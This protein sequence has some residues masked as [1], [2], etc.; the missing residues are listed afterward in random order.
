MS[1]TIPAS[2]YPVERVCPL[3]AHPTM[4][5]SGEGLIG[6]T[7]ICPQCNAMIDD[8][9]EW[10]DGAGNRVLRRSMRGQRGWSA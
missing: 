6:A 5:T 7:D 4:M 10:Y 8:S 2:F 9:G 3:C 1:A